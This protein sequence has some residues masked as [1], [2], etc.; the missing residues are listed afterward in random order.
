[1]MPPLRRTPLVARDRDRATAHLGDE[2]A[3]ETLRVASSAF[4]GTLA[5]SP[6]EN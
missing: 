5:P 4:F 2:S 6:T 3:A 1:M